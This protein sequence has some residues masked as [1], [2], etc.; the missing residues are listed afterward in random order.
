MLAPT[1]TSQAMNNQLRKLLSLFSLITTLIIAANLLNAIAK[2]SFV[3]E[4]STTSLMTSAEIDTTW[5]YTEAGWQ[6]SAV[7][8]SGDTFVPQPVFESVHPII[9]AGL[10]LI[11]VTVVMVW[12]SSEWEVG[13]IG[14]SKRLKAQTSSRSISK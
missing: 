10:I 2:A 13:K 8:D 6:D 9:W 5:R 12:A 11:S 1:L 3:Q 4:K 7:W 14:S